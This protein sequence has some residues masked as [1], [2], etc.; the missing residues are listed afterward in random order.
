M[1]RLAL[2]AAALALAAGG[3]VAALHSAGAFSAVYSVA[4][5]RAELARHPDAWT[6]RSVL[7]RGTVTGFMPGSYPVAARQLPPGF[8]PIAAMLVDDPGA[9][10]PFGGL[11]IALAPEDAALSF[12]RRLPV[13]GRF[14]PRAQTFHWDSAAVYRV[15]MQAAPHG[16]CGRAHCYEAVLLDARPTAPD[17]YMSGPFGTTLRG[18]TISPPPIVLTPRPSHAVP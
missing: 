1:R 17:L 11:P 18:V 3:L 8:L 2:A 14:A 4:A 5:L 16:V 9:T 7:V 6:G 10:K 15:R 13:V 12:L